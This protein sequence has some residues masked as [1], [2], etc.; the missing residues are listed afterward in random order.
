[1]HYAYTIESYYAEVFPRII[2]IL[3]YY[4]RCKL[5]KYFIIRDKSDAE[6][7]LSVFNRFGEVV[8][9]VS[10]EVSGSSHKMILSDKSGKMLSSI[11]SSP[12]AFPHFRVSLGGKRIIFIMTPNGK[13]PMF[14]YG[15]HVSFDGVLLTGEYTLRDSDDKILACQKRSW[16]RQGECSEL[17]VFDENC[18]LLALSVSAA[19]SI[20]YGIYGGSDVVPI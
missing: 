5:M 15:A 16:C 10:G 8:F 9:N 1:M 3:L 12:F 19:I 11:I 18:L 14:V 17:E 6:S 4:R 20:Y 7:R 13:T 2:F